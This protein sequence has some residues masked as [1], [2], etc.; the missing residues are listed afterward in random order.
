MVKM[1]KFCHSNVI[2]MNANLTKPTKTVQLKKK[3]L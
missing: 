3:K 2:T 1:S